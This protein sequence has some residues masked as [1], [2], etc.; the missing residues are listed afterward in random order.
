MRPEHP[1][2]RPDPAAKLVLRG[3]EDHEIG[4]APLQELTAELLEPVS[5]DLLVSHDGTMNRM[6]VM[7][8]PGGVSESGLLTRGVRTRLE[9]LFVCRL[10]CPATS[11]TGWDAKHL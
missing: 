4:C 1:L 8:S 2:Q 5:E 11:G 9:S 7:L 10:S 6:R 3:R